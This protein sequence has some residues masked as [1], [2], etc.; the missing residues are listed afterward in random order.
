MNAFE[1]LRAT[2]LDGREIARFALVELAALLAGALVLVALLVGLLGVN[3]P[4]DP[5]GIVV[6]IAAVTVFAGLPYALAYRLAHRVAGR[7]A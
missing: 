2:G 4:A 5:S 3:M 1:R 6:L 7:Y